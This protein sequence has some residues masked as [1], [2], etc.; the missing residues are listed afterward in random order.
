MTTKNP[1]QIIQDAEAEA[2]QIVHTAHANAQQKISDARQKAQHRIERAQTEHTASDP[3]TQPAL[4][5]LNAE[6]KR[7]IA[8]KLS[9]L[10]RTSTAGEHNQKATH[11]AIRAL[12]SGY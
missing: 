4:D 1:I 9:A 7:M 12:L 6:T 8:E 11:Y 10:N 2:E 3:H 5:A